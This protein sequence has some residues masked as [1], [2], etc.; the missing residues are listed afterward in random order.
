MKT[1]YYRADCTGGF[2]AG[3]DAT[4]RDQVNACSGLGPEATPGGK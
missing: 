2:T 4:A 3:R 1:C